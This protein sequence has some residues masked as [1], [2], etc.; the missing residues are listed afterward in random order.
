MCGGI[1][2][3]VLQGRG[4][5]VD[6]GSGDDIDYQIGESA[7]V[8]GN[9]RLKPIQV[10]AAIVEHSKFP[11][12]PSPRGQPRAL[13]TNHCTRHVPRAAGCINLAWCMVAVPLL[14]LKRCGTTDQFRTTFHFS[15]CLQRAYVV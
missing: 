15:A 7:V 1:V 4:D 10:A 6:F 13:P 2:G 12:L 3:K 5:V 8:A 14:H 11:S 9:G